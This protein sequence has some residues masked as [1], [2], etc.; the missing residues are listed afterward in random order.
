MVSGTKVTVYVPCDV[1]SIR[2][3]L[4]YEDA[5]TPIERVVLRTVYAGL[6]TL[7]EISDALGLGR[8]LTMD[9]VHDL[10]R[11][12]Y[13]RLIR[14]HAGVKVSA[15]VARCIEDGTLDQLKS[16][17]NIDS[18]REVM[19][20]KL[21]GCILP[22]SGPK[23][24]ADR[25]LAVPVENST[26]RIG[27]ATIPELLGAIERG[28]DQEERERDSDPEVR[29][30]F[31]SS[32]RRRVLSARLA[33]DQLGSAGRRWLPL[34]VRAG[35][36]PDTDRLIITVI[37]GVLPE[38]HRAAA[39]EELTRLAAH[40]SKDNFFQALRGRATKGPL[41]GPSVADALT[42]LHD[43]AVTASDIPAGQRRNWHLNLCA[44]ARQ[45]TGMLEDVVDREVS[46]RVIPSA[47]Q[48]EALISLIHS[49][50]A[51][52]VLTAPWVGYDA[53]FAVAPELRA[54]LRR[55]VQVVLLWGIDYDQELRDKVEN[56]LYDMTLRNE[57]RAGGS[58]RLIVPRTSAR[59]HA[60]VAIADDRRALVTS[61]NMVNSARPNL[62]IGLELADPAGDSCRTVV[63]LLRWARTVVPAYEMSLQVLVTRQD[64]ALRLSADETP[65]RELREPE[66]P[67]LGLPDMPLEPSEGVD[68]AAGAEAQAWS[69][70]WA[71]Y[72]DRLAD[73]AASRVQ[74][75]AQ[76]IIDG[77]H[78]DLLWRATRT[79][80]R[81]L[82]IGTDR[83]SGRVAD[84]RLLAGLAEAL[85]RGCQ[86]TVI[87][88]R[89][90]SGED[91]ATPGARSPAEQA[92]H[93]LQARFPDGLR[94]VRNGNHAKILVW[95]DEAAIGSFN[96]LSY[97]G[98]YTL[99]G[100]YRQRS[101]VS[102]RLSGRKAADD[103][104]RA[105]DVLDAVAERPASAE[106]RVGRD[107]A[108]V[109]RDPALLSAQYILRAVATGTTPAEAVREHLSRDG[110]PWQTLERLGGM[111]GR[112][113][114]QLVAAT[115]LS[116]RDGDAP[117]PLRD[118]WS[119]WLV[120][121]LW[122]D[123]RY[124]EAMLIR[125]TVADEEFRPRLDLA[126]LA[127]ARGG[128]Q[129]AA[130]LDQALGMLDTPE[131]AVAA[132]G[133]VTL[134]AAEIRGRWVA[135]RT[136]VLAVA[137][138]QLLFAASPDASTA[139]QL[140]CLQPDEEG[141]ALGRAW[142][143]LADAALEYSTAVAERPLPVD[144]IRSDLDTRD[145][146]E[147]LTAAWA[148]LDTA[149]SRAENTGLHNS[150]SL[151]THMQ[152]FASSDGI[153]ARLKK[154]AS[155]R[156]PAKLRAWLKEVARQ[157]V[158]N[159]INAAAAVAAPGQEPMY[160]AY[161]KRYIK[162][163]ESIIVE[164]RAVVSLS[165]DEEEGPGQDADLADLLAAA[166]PLARAFATS[167]PDLAATAA[168]LPEPE[169]R[170]VRDVLT[171][172][173]VLRDWGKQGRTPARPPAPDGHVAG[174]ASGGYRD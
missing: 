102:V 3:L 145:D 47:D 74:P 2:V 148:R 40:R 20:D 134:E 160:G 19:I 106:V 38:A 33:P 169:G 123:G 89:L 43:D 162:L 96:Y 13:L 21:S 114:L 62:E 73:I 25:K 44:E 135:E 95:D 15:D 49:A 35:V 88:G 164:V 87:Y 129:A 51:Q 119:R 155:D 133:T 149:L 81:R 116:D 84:D 151:R 68:E 122:T 53:L 11:A 41:D 130:A 171:S 29:R 153:F 136:A 71:H 165:G 26:V 140:A 159:L 128:A 17:E 65:L 105:A 138:E 161:R 63:N 78:R 4:G 8:R 70:A 173:G 61:W 108:L 120:S 110:D 45:L 98:F 75:S 28:L 94:I 16:A 92:L 146:R 143:E 109:G 56:L 67:S 170:F 166:R 6:G 66:I 103:T 36:D 150:A 139:V 167:W 1:A 163:L 113:V 100:S 9:V 76:L 77:T 46:A 30:T 90:G 132:D 142:A 69:R 82:I 72:A 55:G 118:R 37:G 104:A 32:R 126:I 18:Q 174:I 22:M 172:F 27:D 127:G 107:E 10:W 158:G 154:D 85:G 7:P 121:N 156:K 144:A 91:V 57:T 60:K 31:G 50:R 157:G 12:G 93:A 152:L 86:V 79:A 14:A 52:I 125:A 54:A 24:P 101:E 39:S 34:D 83:L 59:T 168:A 131:G 147:A 5:L 115:C 23:A 111:A 48:P 42:R 112:E 137:L 117:A 141:A 64:F 99:G 58:G 80:K 124:T 97:E